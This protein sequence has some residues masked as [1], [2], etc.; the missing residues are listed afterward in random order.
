MNLPKAMHRMRAE[1][2]FIGVA[3]LGLIACGLAFQFGVLQPLE[4]RRMSLE[5]RITQSLVPGRGALSDASSGLTLP[6]FYR[7]FE[8]TDDAPTQLARLHTIGKAAGLDLRSA[9]YKVDRSGPRILRYE[10]T[11]PLSGSYSQIRSFLKNAL[12]E[13]PVLSLDQV[14]LKKDRPGEGL[15]LADVRMTLHLLQ[16]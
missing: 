15:V 1:L 13:I 3:S 8:S 10:I 11:L 9:Q 5:Q 14:N 7:F 6:R 16:P 12:A 4:A 2:G